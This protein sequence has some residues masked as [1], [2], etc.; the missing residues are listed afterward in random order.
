MAGRQSFKL[1]GAKELESLLK[2]LGPEAATKAGAEGLRKAA[3]TVRDDV[4]AAAPYDDGDTKR[5]WR[6]KD[7]SQGSADYGHLRDNIKL[8]KRKA[9]KAHSIRYV[10][11][12]TNAFW[13]LFSEFGTEHEPARPWMRPTLERSANGFFDQ[14][15]DT[16]RKAI[17]KAARKAKK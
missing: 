11:T 13:G 2:G 17:N 4:K 12:T 1:T 8:R 9:L 10:L 14:L 5:T 7:G 15:S 16:L 3:E 6:N